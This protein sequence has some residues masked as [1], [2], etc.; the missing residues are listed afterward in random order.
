MTNDNSFSS[1]GVSWNLTCKVVV[2]ED[3]L[4]K[5]T[6]ALD[7]TSGTTRIRAQFDTAKAS[8]DNKHGIE[9]ESDWVNISLLLQKQ[10]FCFSLRP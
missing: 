8:P 1:D 4:Y 3:A 6:E 2:P 7:W 5:S 10:C 9:L